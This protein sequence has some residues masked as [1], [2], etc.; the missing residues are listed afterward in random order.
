MISIF[1]RCKSFIYLNIHICQRYST[2]LLSVERIAFGLYIVM[3]RVNCVQHTPLSSSLS[4]RYIFQ[5]C[6]LVV[7]VFFTENNNIE[8]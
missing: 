1:E 7:V 6:I 2:G 3:R 4:A 8:R 5:V